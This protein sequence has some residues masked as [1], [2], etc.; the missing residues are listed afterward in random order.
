[1]TDLI[2]IEDFFRKPERCAVSISPDGQKLAWLEPLSLKNETGRNVR[3]MNLFVAELSNS[4]DS[5]DPS[6]AVQRTAIT[7]RDIVEYFF[8]DADHLIYAMDQDGDENFHL[9]VVN[10]T[11]GEPRDVTPFEN[12]MCLIVDDL[13]DVPGEVLFQMNRRDPE[14][15]DVYRLDIVT[16][17]MELVAENPGNVQSWVTD[18]AGQLRF[19]TTTD[20]VD[21][22]LLYRATEQDEFR[23]IGTYDFKESVM[24]LCFTFDN[25]KLWVAS[26]VGRERTAIFEMDPED[27]EFTKLVFEHDE[28]DVECLL[29]SKKRRVSCGA[30]YET[31]YFH[32]E[33]WDTREA[34]LQNFVDDRLPDTYNRFTSCDLSE[35]RYIVRTSSDREIGGY[36]LLD[37]PYDPSD[38]A[39][40]KAFTLTHLFDLA[41]WLDSEKL[42]DMQPIRYS[43]RDGREIPGYL[44]LPKRSSEPVPLIALPHG[45]PWLRDSWGFNPEVQFLA[46]RGYAVLQMNYRGSTGYG[47][48]HLETSFGEWG[49]TM[50]D[51]ITDGVHWAIDAGYADPKR[52]A[53]YGGSYGGYA[54]LSGITKTPELYRCAVDYVGVSNLFTWIESIPPYWRPMLEMLH[55]KVGHPERNKE[56]FR[57]TSPV[58][59]IEKIQCPLFVAQ[60]ANDP[61]VRQEESEQIVDALRAKGIS[62][63]YMLKEDEGHGFCNEENR[64]EFYHAMEAFFAQHLA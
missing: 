10:T 28:V 61:R 53:I 56:R 1:M 9:W 42:C 63:E 32:N 11:E 59:H 8:A 14:R 29:A 49:L 62:V 20:G 17:E 37:A 36:Y 2:P 41:P 5:F 35:Q 51:D 21:T 44:T 57:A 31:D 4:A 27:G 46:N 7:Q 12:V 24:P 6:T 45:G 43:A 38:E 3:R 15:F 58:F 39:N 22:S 26:N 18:H 25:Q 50:Q 16:G 33:F 48:D 55:E 40:A 47:R 54:A 64:L 52:V 19:A 13:E 60:G 23:M 30:R 34:T